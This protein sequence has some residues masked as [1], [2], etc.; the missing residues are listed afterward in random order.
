MLVPPLEDRTERREARMG[1]PGAALRVLATCAAIGL[2]YYGRTFFVTVVIASMIAMLLGPLV[3][4]VMRLRLPR[5]VASFAVCSLALAVLY[6][7]GVGI[8]TQSLAVI[9][10]LPAYSDRINELV[11]SAAQ[12]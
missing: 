10:D 3:D 2:L 4:G 1:V 11:D 8:Y 7:V 12:R 6:V 9:A 5:G